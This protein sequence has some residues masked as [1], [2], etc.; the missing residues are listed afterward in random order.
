MAE[1][2]YHQKV[3]K[4]YVEEHP[5]YFACGKKD[6]PRLVEKA[7]K[8]AAQILNEFSMFYVGDIGIEI[9]VKEYPICWSITA[10]LT[11]NG[12]PVKTE[13]PCDLL[14]LELNNLMLNRMLK[15]GMVS[16][17]KRKEEKE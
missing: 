1:L 12:K 4:K 15:G 17:G 2:S 14:F 8:E 16:F 9:G 3:H 6:L 11:V 7:K 10:T 13:N 5:D